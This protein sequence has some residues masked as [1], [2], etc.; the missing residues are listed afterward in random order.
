MHKINN[1]IITMF[2]YLYFVKINQYFLLTFCNKGVKNI[3]TISNKF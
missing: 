3:D 1:I 2:H